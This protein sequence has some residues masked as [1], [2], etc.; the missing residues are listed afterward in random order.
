MIKI[1][2]RKNRLLRV[3]EGYLEFIPKRWNIDI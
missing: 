3:G 1:N 2:K